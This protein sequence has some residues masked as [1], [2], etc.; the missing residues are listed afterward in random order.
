MESKIDLMKYQPLLHKISNQFPEEYKDDL[1]SEGFL[2]L[3]HASLNFDETRGVPFESF[4]YKR[5]HYSMIDFLNGENTNT[6]SLD[7]PICDEDGEESTYADLIE[8][9]L[10]LYEQIENRDYYRK[11][12]EA[13][14]VIERFVKDRYLNEDM[15]PK[16]IVDVYSEITNIR[17]VRKIKKI[18]K[19]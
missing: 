14:D 18:L 2:A 12:I 6:V 3:H 16:Q 13:S 7:N 17:D 19:K 5:V 15:T 8:D 9:D 10:D 4:A 1:M 11:N